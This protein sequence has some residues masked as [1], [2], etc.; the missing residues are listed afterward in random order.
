MAHFRTHE[1]GIENVLDAVETKRGEGWTHLQLLVGA[2]QLA[3]EVR[4][5]QG[6]LEQ[7]REERDQLD[8]LAYD[9]ELFGGAE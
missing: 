7:V 6:E 3:A 8:A 2:R 4:K 1:E 9:L 5:L